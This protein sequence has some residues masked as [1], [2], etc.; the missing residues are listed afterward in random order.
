[1]RMNLQIEKSFR[2]LLLDKL[3]VVVPEACTAHL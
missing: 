1:M 2:N 3:L